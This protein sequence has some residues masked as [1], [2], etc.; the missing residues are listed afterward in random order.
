[1]KYKHLVDDYMAEVHKHD[2]WLRRSPVNPHVT[3]VRHSDYTPTSL[4]HRSVFY[5]RLLLPSESEYGASVVAWRDTTWLATLTMMRN[6]EQG[7][8]SDEHLR[9][10]QALQP[11]FACVIRR[12]AKTSGDPPRGFFVAP[13]HVFAPHRDSHI[14]T[15]I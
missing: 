2:I 8:F 12:L 3:V 5:K 9:E 15:G 4:L 14:W 1:M 11:H 6:K 7:D 13:L 10:L